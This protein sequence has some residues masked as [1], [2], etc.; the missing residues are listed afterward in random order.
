MYAFETLSYLL[1]T[2]KHKNFK[3]T[4]FLQDIRKSKSK[5]AF[6]CWKCIFFSI[7]TSLTKSQQYCFLKTSISGSESRNLI[8]AINMN[9]KLAIRKAVDLNSIFNTRKPVIKALWTTKI[10]LKTRHIFKNCNI[11]LKTLTFF[12]SKFTLSKVKSE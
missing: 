10:N 2:L 5:I 3:K 12:K 7:L 4:F 1:E 11:Y 9:T 8:H 6:L